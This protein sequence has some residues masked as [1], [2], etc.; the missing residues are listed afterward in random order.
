MADHVLVAV[1]FS[2]QWPALRAAIERLCEKGYRRMTLVHVLAEGY[3]RIPDTTHREHYVQELE[4]VA[5]TL[6]GQGAEVNGEVRS[7]SVVNELLQAAD[8]HGA[9]L[10][11]IGKRGRN[12]VIDL[13]LGSVA[14]GVCRHSRLPVLLIP[15]KEA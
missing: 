2:S 8:E 4:A 3:G 1:D 15:V 10:I 5:A 11:A 13:L 12:P 9:D 7:G 14:E 6:R